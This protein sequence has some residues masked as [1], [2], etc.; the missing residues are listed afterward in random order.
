MPEDSPESYLGFYLHNC[1]PEAYQDIDLQPIC[2]IPSLN[3]VL[4]LSIKVSLPKDSIKARLIR[5]I[6]PKV[7]IMRIQWYCRISI[8]SLLILINIKSYI[9][10]RK[11]R[12]CYQEHKRAMARD[13]NRSRV[14]STESI[15]GRQ[16]L[17]D[18]IRARVPKDP[19]KFWEY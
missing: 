10:I 6:M 18:K 7:L 17:M 14:W 15:D 8:L 3:S 13:V 19:K 9:I 2:R 11:H 4:S 1:C 16:P 12:F 5:F